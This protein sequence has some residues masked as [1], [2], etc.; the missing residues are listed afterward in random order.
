MIL[1]LTFLLFIGCTIKIEPLPKPKPRIVYVHK[2]KHHR[3]H[4]VPTPSPLR[5][6]EPADQDV[7]LLPR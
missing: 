5:N 1:P 3:G 2:S 4:G 7:I 6:M